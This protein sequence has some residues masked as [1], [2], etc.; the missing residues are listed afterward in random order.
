MSTSPGDSDSPPTTTKTV[1][2]LPTKVLVVPTDGLF[3]FDSAKPSEAGTRLAKTIA[4]QLF[5]ARELTIVGHTDSKGADEGNERLGLQRAK[6]FAA[7][8]RSEGLDGTKVVVRSAGEG[9][10][11]ASNDTERGRQLNRRVEVT[12]RY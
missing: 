4:S 2:I 11:R 7:L 6:A 12:V 1:R 5:G 9:S 10:P 3:G 8:L